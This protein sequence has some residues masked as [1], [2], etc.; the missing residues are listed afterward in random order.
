MRVP[1]ETSLSKIT[2]LAAENVAGRRSDGE[3]IQEMDRSVAY[4][5]LDEIFRQISTAAK[6]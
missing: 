5:G 1:R 2:L 6:K 4:M 3:Q